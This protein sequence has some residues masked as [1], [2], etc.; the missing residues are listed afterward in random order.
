MDL[1]VLRIRADGDMPCLALSEGEL[2]SA[3][4]HADILGFPKSHGAPDDI[5]LGTDLKITQGIVTSV[6]TL[7]SG[8]NDWSVDGCD[9]L[10]DAKVNAGNSGGP[11]IDRR[12]RVMAV[13]TAKT[14]DIHAFEESYGIGI[15][16]GHLRTFLRSCGV[17]LP[18]TKQSLNELDD[19]A[20][21]K[22]SSPAIVR[23][24]GSD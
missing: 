1:A 10:L 14:S 13:I 2:P 20:I 8:D 24:E 21:F 6:H 22:N 7:D 19:E 5:T 15:S 17:R 16:A 12:G 9:V 11:I 23:V 3:G 4:A 18:D